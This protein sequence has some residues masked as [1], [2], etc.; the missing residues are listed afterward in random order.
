MQHE[1]AS[2]IA[3]LLLADDG[4]LARVAKS[5][6]DPNPNVMTDRDG[7]F[8]AGSLSAGCRRLCRLLS[9]KVLSRSS[10]G[11]L[12]PC[13]APTWRQLAPS[14]WTRRDCCIQGTALTIDSPLGTETRLIHQLGGPSDQEVRSIC[15]RHA[16]REPCAN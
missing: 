11:T 2:G 5:T 10:M 4:L 14:F 16:V 3:Q 8:G 7:D 13:F 9:D 1:D 15:G 12:G 6:S